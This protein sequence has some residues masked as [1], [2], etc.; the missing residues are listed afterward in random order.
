LFQERAEAIPQNKRNA[1]RYHRVTA[2][3]TL[4][5]VARTYRVG[6]AELAEVNQLRP[7]Q[8]VSGLE[9]LVVPVAPLAAPAVHTVLYTA[10]RGD[11]LVSIADRFGVSLDQLRRWNKIPTG[12]R[13]EPG[14][15]LHVA[16]PA[17]AR[18]T[19]GRRRTT[20]TAADLSPHRG[21]GASAHQ[22]PTTASKKSTHASSSAT[23][24][25]THANSQS[26][27]QK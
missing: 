17:L 21:S 22:A 14:S 15:R 20:I 1:W 6:V 11:T 8:S 7:G 19:K 24:H 9:A 3:D 10:R 2:D 12:I 5:T 18:R 27:A 4:E 23:R 26:N 16:E 25:K 13:V